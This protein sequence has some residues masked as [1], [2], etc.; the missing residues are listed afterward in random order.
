VAGRRLSTGSGVV[1]GEALGQSQTMVM[2]LPRNL[3]NGCSYRLK[4]RL[5]AI[6]R[7]NQVA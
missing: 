4:N 6:E 3:H 1:A 5:A 7:D 2:R